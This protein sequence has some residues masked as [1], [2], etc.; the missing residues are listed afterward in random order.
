MKKIYSSKTLLQL[1]GGGDASPTSPPSRSATVDRPIIIKL[2]NAADKRRIFANLKNLK[3]FN[4]ARSMQN[5]R[6]TYVTEHLPK[7][8]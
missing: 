5:Q 4:E 7:R 1:A 6:P 3:A 2:T 8:T